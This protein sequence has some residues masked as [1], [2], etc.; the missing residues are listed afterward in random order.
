MSDDWMAFALRPGALFLVGDPKQAIYRFRGADIAAYVRARE[1]F[2]AGDAEGVLSIATNFRSRAP[3]MEYVNARFET[4]LSEENGQP[5]FPGSRP[6]PDAAG[7]GTLGRRARC[8]GGRRGRQGQ[9]APAARWRG[10]GR[11]RTVR[12]P[13]RRRAGPRLHERRA[14]ARAGPAISPCWRRP[15]TTSGGTRKRWKSAASPSPPR[16]ARASTGAR[17]S[18]T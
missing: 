4:A 6:I 15:G 14:P 5:G 1:A 7:R 13:D 12:T 2:R 11:R 16:R 17:K 8:R 10:R 3:I 18:R 9:C